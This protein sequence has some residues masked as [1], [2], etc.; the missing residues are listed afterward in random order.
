MADQWGGLHPIID[1]RVEKQIHALEESLTGK[2]IQ[3]KAAIVEEEKASLA[4]FA[5]QVKGSQAALRLEIEDVQ[6]AQ[7]QCQ[8]TTRLLLESRDE[9]A[10]RVVN[11][12]TQ[13]ERAARTVAST[14][15]AVDEGKERYGRLEEIVAGMREQHNAL[16]TKV[17]TLEQAQESATPS[18]THTDDGR[19]VVTLPPQSSPNNFTARAASDQHLSLKGIAEAAQQ[20]S[21]PDLFYTPQVEPSVGHSSLETDSSED[22]YNATP[23]YER[24]RK[25]QEFLRG[26]QRAGPASGTNWAFDHASALS[27]RGRRVEGG[28]SSVTYFGDEGIPRLHRARAKPP[29]PMFSDNRAP[30]SVC[31]SIEAGLPGADD[32]EPALA[33]SEER[34]NTPGQASTVGLE[35]IA[36]SSASTGLLSNFETEHKRQKLTSTAA[37][38]IIRAVSDQASQ[39]ASGHRTEDNGHS[40]P[41]SDTIVVAPRRIAPGHRPEDLDVV[42]AVEH[43]LLDNKER[44]KDS[45]QKTPET[46]STASVFTAVH[47]P[48]EVDNPDQRSTGREYYTSSP[49]HT[50]VSG[51]LRLWKPRAER[52]EKE[53]QLSAPSPVGENEEMEGIAFGESS[54]GTRNR[55][56]SRKSEEQDADSTAAAAATRRSARGPMKRKPRD[57]EITPEEAV[58]EL[59]AANLKQKR[60]AKAAKLPA[61]RACRR[62]K[63]KCEHKGEVRVASEEDLEMEVL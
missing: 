17:H 59:E 42:N 39:D 51:V 18:I 57:D 36:P 52:I 22:F 62:A 61:C 1:G 5:E 26:Q 44:M 11:L 58:R 4:T 28:A 2:A 9:L 63:T 14:K 31:E 56:P 45:S 15:A 48:K 10:N 34:R 46:A 16:V 60:E 8:M 43:N 32:D 3:W 50:T 30:S 41:G 6:A 12:Q 29:V 55:R 35:D 20:A 38:S 7:Q 37:T 19:L 25:R 24:E 23:G 40:L 21:T 27:I 49:Q 33:Q 54:R 13:L 47:E 53:T